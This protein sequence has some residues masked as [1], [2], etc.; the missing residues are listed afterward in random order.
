MTH[1]AAGGTYKGGLEDI[2]S[3]AIVGK[4]V[5]VPE[6]LIHR[7]ARGKVVEGCIVFD[8]LG[9]WGQLGVAPPMAEGGE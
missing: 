7:V 5:I 8:E 1:V 3:A 6:I 9:L 2:P 4:Q